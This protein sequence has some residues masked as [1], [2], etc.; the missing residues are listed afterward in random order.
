ME[1]FKN[2]AVYFFSQGYSCSEAMIQAAS[3]CNIL[4]TEDAKILN[5]A[6]TAYS[7]GMGH[8]CLC[9]AVAGVEMIVGYLFGREDNSTSP[10][11]AKKLAAELIDKFR[12]KRKVTCCKALSAKYEFTSPERRENCKNIV[13]DAAETLENIIKTNIINKIDK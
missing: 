1:N 8:G 10:S 9:G 13:Y 11:E 6:A 12:E 3:D 4:D 5:K 7:G 2:K